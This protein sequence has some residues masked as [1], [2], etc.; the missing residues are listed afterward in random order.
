MNNET[1]K[2]RGSWMFDTHDAVYHLNEVWNIVWIECGKIRDHI[3]W[4]HTSS[5]VSWYIWNPW[6]FALSGANETD[7]EMI[8]T[9]FTNTYSQRINKWI[10]LKWSSKIEKEAA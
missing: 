10:E 9:Q 5:R 3:V 6:I 2:F 7:L 1:W 4:I 8:F